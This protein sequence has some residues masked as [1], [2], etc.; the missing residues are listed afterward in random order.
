MQRWLQEVLGW[1]RELASKR[2]VRTLR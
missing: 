1:I 2:D